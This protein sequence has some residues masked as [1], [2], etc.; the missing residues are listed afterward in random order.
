[1]GWG[2]FD[3]ST[4]ATFSGTVTFPDQFPYSALTGVQRSEGWTGNTNQIAYDFG[5]LFSTSASRGPLV[6]ETGT[7]VPRL[8]AN[9]HSDFHFRLWVVPSLLQLNNPQIGIDIPFRI[10]STGTIFETFTNILVSGSSV[11]SFDISPGDVIRDFEY[12]VVNMQI[13]AGEAS[14][15][16]IV[17]FSTTNLV[18]Y[19]TVIATISDTFNLIPDVPIKEQWEFKTDVL[20]NHLG[21]EQRI[22]LRRRPRIRQEFTFEIIN[23]RQRREQYNVTR[24]NILSRSLVPMYQ[25]SVNLDQPATIG[26]TRLY[27]NNSQSNLRAGEFAIIVNPTTEQ[28]IISKIA[29]IETDG[30]TLESPISFDIDDHW[31]VAPVINAVINDG[32]G[33][34]MRNVTGQLKITADSFTEP[35]LLR[36][37]ATRTVEMFDGIPFINRRPLINADEN[38][39]FERE[40]FDNETGVRDIDSGWTHPKISGTRKFL[41]QR[42]SDPEEMDYWRSVFD[43][44]RGGQKSFLLSTFFPDLTQVNPNQNVRGLSTILIKE[45][46]YP[47]LYWTYDTWKRIQIEYTSKNRSQ[48]VV[49]NATTNQD[50]TANIQLSPVIPDL[51]GYETVKYISFLMRWRATDTIVFNHWANYSEV[52]FGVFSSDE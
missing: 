1:M 26:A 14:I 38:F 51:N 34:D 49:M 6:P 13:D 16:A 9:F 48:H 25:Y 24:K 4:Y 41:I 50:G 2:F 11:L 45:G 32:S 18:G 29:V 39:N 20:T 3:Y 28:L 21:V 23:L 22:C 19:L 44:V 5:Y 40:I 35:A 17:E 10:W 43:T 37:N 30:I 36:P 12:L 27:L 47:A 7:G 46:Y 8:Q 31:V 42:V 15:E 52:S 33:I